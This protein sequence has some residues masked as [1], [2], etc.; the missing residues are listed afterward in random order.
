MVR[1]MLQYAVPPGYQRQQPINR[2][3][4]GPWVG[5]IDA[6]LEDDKQKPAKQR[7][8][9]RRIFD[10]LQAEHGFTGGYTTIKNYVRGAHVRGREMFV[11]LLHPPGEAQVDFGEALVIIAGVECKAHFLAMDMPHSDDCF[12]TAFPAETTEAFL[13]GHLRAFEYFGAV[14]TRI[15]YDNTRIAVA[16]ILPPQRRRAC[17]WG[18]RLWAASSGRRRAPSPNCR[19]I[20]YSLISSG[21]RPRATIKVRSRVWWAMRGAISWCRFRA[22]KAGKL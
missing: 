2:P 7:H 1:K 21:G 4:L 8:T 16:K 11:P 13:E 22:S 15:L 18:P 5:V 10:R 19:A 17:R 6:I 9:A 14:P 3:M 20:T 12:V